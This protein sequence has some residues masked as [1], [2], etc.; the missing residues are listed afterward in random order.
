MRCNSEKRKTK[1]RLVS[2]TWVSPK[3]ALNTPV[4]FTTGRK[5][6]TCFRIQNNLFKLIKPME[7]KLFYIAEIIYLCN[8]PIIPYEF[9]YHTGHF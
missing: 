3:H 8:T 6:R 7:G 1:E 4:N 2:R 9:L 5:K